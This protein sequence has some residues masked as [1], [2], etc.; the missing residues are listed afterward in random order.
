VRGLPRDVWQAGKLLL[1]AHRDLPDYGVAMRL[2]SPP[3]LVA[4]AL[5]VPGSLVEVALVV[6]VWVLRLVLW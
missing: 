1:A 4:V 5:S 2:I 6:P 3:F